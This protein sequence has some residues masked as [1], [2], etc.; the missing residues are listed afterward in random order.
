MHQ[1]AANVHQR[2]PAALHPISDIGRIGIEVAEKTSDGAEPSDAAFGEQLLNAEPLRIAANHEGLAD[3]D[4]RPRAHGQQGFSF[5]SCQAERLLAEH[6]LAG[7]RRG[8]GDF[9]V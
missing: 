2:A 5:S 1:I 7:A 4:S 8:D 3:L 9:R 6:M